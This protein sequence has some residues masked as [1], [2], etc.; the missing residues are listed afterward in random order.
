MEN[1]KQM[2]RVQNS[3]DPNTATILIVGEAPGR[4]EEIY[5]TPFVG[6]SGKELRRMLEVAGIDIS[7]CL[8]TNVC[9][10][11]PPS[12]DI[13]AFFFNKTE[14]KKNGVE[15]LNGKYPNILIREGIRELKTL[16]SSMPNLRLILCFGETALW[17]LTSKSGIG[18]WHGSYFEYETGAK[19]VPLLATYHP[20]AVLRM[21]NLRW[22]VVHDLKKAR[23][24]VKKGLRPFPYAEHAILNPTFEFARENLLAL[25]QE[26]DKAL[27]A[28]ISFPLS[29]DIETIKPF[30][31]CIGIAKS[32]SWAIVIPLISSSPP[33]APLSQYSD[34]ERADLMF[35][36]RQ[37]LSH[38][39]VL[40]IGQNFSY[41]L[42]YLCRDLCLESY[43]YFWDTM[44][45]HHTKYPMFPKGLDDLATFYLPCHVFW[46]HEG[47]SWEF[48][49]VPDEQ[50]WLY[51]AKDACIT[52]AIAKQ[53]MREIGRTPAFLEQMRIAKRAL[54]ATFRGTRIDQKR[55]LE[56]LDSIFE[57]NQKFENYFF[58]LV[59]SEIF[60]RQKT[61]F[62]RSPK[63]LGE[64]LYVTLHQSP[65]YG[66]S[67]SYTA[68]DAALLSVAKREPLLAPLCHGILR[69]RSLENSFKVLSRNVDADGRMRCLY[70]TTGTYTFRLA[71][72]E[73]A[74]GSGTNLQNLTKGEPE[75]RNQY[76]LP[77]DI[78][79]PNIRRIF[80]PD[81][82]KLL[83]DCDLARADAQAVAGYADDREMIAAFQTD[84][85][86]HLFNAVTF[87]DLPV[88]IDETC[89]SHPNYPLHKDKYGK[90]RHQMK[91]G[92]HAT[93]YGVQAR[94][95]SHSLN[96]TVHE[97]D[98]FINRWFSIH[99]KIRDWQKE[100]DFRLATNK[101]LVNVWG[102][103]CQFPMRAGVDLM[104]KGLAWLG[105][106]TIALYINK[107]WLAIIDTLP[108]VEDLM[109]V[110]DSLVLQIP[111]NRW[112]DRHLI[113]EAASIPI[114]FS[115]PFV[116]RL[117]IAYSSSSWGEVKETTWK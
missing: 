18:S 26:A 43:N 46:K 113:S 31:S 8:I 96:C 68:D 10:F 111:K 86:M 74:F 33:R 50:L 13:K 81:P 72:R 28:S 106:S 37:L 100:V 40:L 98:H 82:G 34:S 21:W 88:P 105:Q 35:L 65:N 115:F 29:V 3:G 87:Y 107:I 76:D 41:D 49:Q 7:S 110:H 94:T 99:P 70:D 109:Q 75:Y 11:R 102:Y 54:A 78:A 20:A 17:A 97:A 48:G 30:I 25:I 9:P 38:R 61:P 47:K 51:N 93:N 101:T 62:F 52:F 32:E 67:G 95:L 19:T 66:E 83:L 2:L 90:Q 23:N 89:E 58:S 63:Q 27:D 73:S 92:V 112:N 14:A 45:A 1:S 69:Y 80:V 79:L 64:L 117:G 24:W 44:I 16:I 12:N 42:Q 4:D 77:S 6:G 104:Q 108:W 57:A 56:Y 53:Q 36:L 103:E 15:E 116:I 71:S 5:L 22:Q 59:P 60:P 91:G 114:P 84:A 85:D 55:R 39:A